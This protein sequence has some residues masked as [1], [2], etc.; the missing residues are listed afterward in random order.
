M[1]ASG[2]KMGPLEDMQADIGT[3]A[4]ASSGE[5]SGPQEIRKPTKI[6]LPTRDVCDC[7]AAPE[8]TE[9]TLL[10]RPTRRTSASSLP[11]INIT[12]TGRGRM[13]C[14]LPCFSLSGASLCSRQPFYPATTAAGKG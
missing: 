8:S 11:V 7:T 2:S 4:E 3:D 5:L 14:F 12:K 10:W 9:E 13:F 6:L 1:A